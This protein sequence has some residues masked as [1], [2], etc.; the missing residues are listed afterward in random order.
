MSEASRSSPWTL[1]QKQKHGSEEKV[2]H[3]RSGN[4]HLAHDVGLPAASEVVPE[5]LL[6]GSQH[7]LYGQ[8][9]GRGGRKTVFFWELFWLS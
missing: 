1:T 7:D 2:K 5:S 9:H 3:T 4:T 6:Q 8:G